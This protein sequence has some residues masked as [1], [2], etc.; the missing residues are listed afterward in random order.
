MYT[1]RTEQAVYWLTLIVLSLG[2][3]S[4]CEYCAPVILVLLA[5]K[6]TYKTKRTLT[7]ALTMQQLA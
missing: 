7:E 1:N 6:V 5:S 4:G 2:S 3:L